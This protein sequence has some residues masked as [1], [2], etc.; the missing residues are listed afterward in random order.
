MSRFP[1]WVIMTRNLFNL[2]FTLVVL[3]GYY[4]LDATIIVS[5]CV[6]DLVRKANT[7]SEF[8]IVAMRV[9]R[10]MG[11]GLANLVYPGNREPRI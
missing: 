11:Q 10:L 7:Y 9:R 8:V 6:R 4:C 5:I 2:V 3:M 1:N